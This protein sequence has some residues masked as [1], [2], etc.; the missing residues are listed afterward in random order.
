[1]VISFSRLEIYVITRSGASEHDDGGAL[2]ICYL[3]IGWKRQQI[4]E[5]S[6]K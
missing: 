4:K 3:C 5:G 2:A 6:G 1:M